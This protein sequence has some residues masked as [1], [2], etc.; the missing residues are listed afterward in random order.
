MLIDMLKY[1]EER[2][3]T[4]LALEASSL[5]LV[6][7]ELVENPRARLRR[8]GIGDDPSRRKAVIRMFTVPPGK[9]RGGDADP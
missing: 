8:R 3:G 1:I 9:T 6:D 7:E 5:T 4:A 2:A